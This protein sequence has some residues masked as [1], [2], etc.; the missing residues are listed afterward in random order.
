MAIGVFGFFFLFFF[1]GG[2]ET[3][4]HVGLSGSANLGIFVAH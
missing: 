2:G 1:R 4:L 3:V